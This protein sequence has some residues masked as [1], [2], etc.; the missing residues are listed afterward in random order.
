MER[1][2][3]LFAMVVIFA[4]AYLSRMHAKDSITPFT[5]ELTIFGEPRKPEFRHRII[6]VILMQAD[7]KVERASTPGSAQLLTDTI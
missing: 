3:F 2:S 1:F 4:D 7:F 5:R 6:S